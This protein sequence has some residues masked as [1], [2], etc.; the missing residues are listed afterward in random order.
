MIFYLQFR[1]LDSYGSLNWALLHELYYIPKIQLRPL[2]SH[3]Y[4]REFDQIRI[5][6][7]LLGSI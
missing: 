1:K 7:I 2:L 4:E 5:G 6:T 3:A